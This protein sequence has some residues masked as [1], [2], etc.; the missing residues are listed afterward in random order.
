MFFFFYEW[1]Q[2][3]AL[4]PRKQADTAPDEIND[5]LYME[6]CYGIRIYLVWDFQINNSVI[7]CKPLLYNTLEYS[8]LKFANEI[9]LNTSI[10]LNTCLY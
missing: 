4:K 1:L 2:L 6:T 9:R 3:M 5:S 10:S 7:N 8:Q